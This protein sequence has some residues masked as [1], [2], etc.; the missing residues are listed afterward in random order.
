MPGF[1][2]IAGGPEVDLILVGHSW[3]NQRGRFSARKVAIAST[4]NAIGEILRITTRMDIYQACHKIGIRCARN[5]PE[6]YLDRAGHLDIL[7]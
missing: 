4:D 5:G 2:D 7:F 6:I 1:K 3:L